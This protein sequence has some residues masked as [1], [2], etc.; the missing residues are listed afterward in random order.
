M[1]KFFLKTKDGD[2][3]NYTTQKDEILAIKYFCKMK[4][5]NR[6]DLLRIFKIEKE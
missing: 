3:I 2:V 5:L 6:E 4:K 1:G